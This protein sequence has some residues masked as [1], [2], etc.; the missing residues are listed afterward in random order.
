MLTSLHVCT[1]IVTHFISCMKGEA[2]CIYFLCNID[3]CAVDIHCAAQNQVIDILCGKS[4][5]VSD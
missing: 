2:S 4:D 1:C 5:V 3:M